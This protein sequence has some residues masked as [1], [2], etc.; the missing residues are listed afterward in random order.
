MITIDDKKVLFAHLIGVGVDMQHALL[1]VAE[2]VHK[3]GTVAG[4]TDV[5]FNE[6]SKKKTLNFFV[7]KVI[8][9]KSLDEGFLK[10]MWRAYEHKYNGN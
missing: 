4:Y 7:D 3:E 6:E 2:S 10:A 8:E 9:T 5:P 1:Q